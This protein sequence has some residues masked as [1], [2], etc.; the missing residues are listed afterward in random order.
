[1]SA[2]DLWL[3]A[4]GLAMDCFTVSIASGIILQKYEWSPILL[5]AFFFG[6]FQ[7]LMP[8]VSWSLFI[9]ISGLVQQI[10]H[11]I[12]FA[13]LL[14]LGI[15]MIRE[16]FKSEEQERFFN[17][18][19][20]IVVLTLAIATSIDALAVGISFAFT[21]FNTLRS[22]S[23]PLLIIGCVS[24]AF[25]FAGSLLGIHFG[26]GIARKL[27]PELLGGIILIAIGCKILYQHITLGL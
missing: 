21:G 12:A 17:P 9:H 13:L 19:R 16:S 25:S 7:A 23:F 15:N 26:K 4:I 1:M 8:L 11:W 24:F 2:I 5:M 22:L 27:H 14:F 3:L 20:L 6:L 10:D 18:R